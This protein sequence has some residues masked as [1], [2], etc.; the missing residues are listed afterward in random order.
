MTTAAQNSCD[1]HAFG[2]KNKNG[3]TIVD[4]LNL[5]LSREVVNFLDLYLNVA[6]QLNICFSL[7]LQFAL[8]AAEEIEK[9]DNEIN[10]GDA[11]VVYTADDYRRRAH[12][13]LSCVIDVDRADRV[14]DMVELWANAKQS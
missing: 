12:Y 13:H 3:E 9:M 10:G 8:R 6:R 11:K 14:F 4:Y 5:Q 1:L 2:I 7:A